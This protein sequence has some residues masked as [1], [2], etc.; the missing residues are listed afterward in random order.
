M[1][2][3]IEALMFILAHTAEPVG[4]GPY[5]DAYTTRLPEEFGESIIYEDERTINDTTVNLEFWYDPEDSSFSIVAQDGTFLCL[6]ASG[7]LK[8]EEI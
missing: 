2:P 4:C 7:Y 5:N 6:F 1:T 8:G 3:V